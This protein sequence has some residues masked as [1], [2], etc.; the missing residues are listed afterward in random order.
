MCQPGGGGVKGLSRNTCATKVHPVGDYPSF[1]SMKQLRLLLL[2]SAPPP[3]LPGRDAGPS[4]G[5]LNSITAL[6]RR[7]GM[8][9]R[10]R[11]NNA[12]ARP[13]LESEEL[14]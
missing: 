11:E 8:E 12:M 1:R 5:H 7:R 9:L 13:A 3:P 4:L 6:K 14:S 10:F 2:P